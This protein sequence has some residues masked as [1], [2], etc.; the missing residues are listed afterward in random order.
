[1]LGLS[2]TALVAQG[3]S[4]APLSLMPDPSS[5]PVPPALDGTATEN[6]GAKRSRRRAAQNKSAPP[7]KDLPGAPKLMGTT[8]IE[9]LSYAPLAVPQASA[10]V[11]PDGADA[12][13]SE[14]HTPA[15]ANLARA[16]PADVPLP[17]ARPGD[18][19]GEISAPAQTAADLTQPSLFAGVG[20]SMPIEE[21]YAESEE[22]RDE[23]A[24]AVIADGVRSRITLQPSPGA[25]TQAP[26]EKHPQVASLP[27]GSV[28]T[29]GARP[30]VA[31]PGSPDMPILRPST[32]RETELPVPGMNSVY[33]APEA[34][35][36]CLPDGLK[37]VLQDVADKFGHVAILNTRRGR[38][39]GA[40]QSYHYQ[41]RAADFRV[42]GVPFREVMAFLRE[43]PNVGGRKLYP[44][45][46]FHIDDGP[47]RSW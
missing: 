3:A 21:P 42:R 10:D 44:F 32:L 25:G 31:L 26:A 5:L 33:A 28:P 2:P 6:A 37:Q 46:F 24:A 12:A 23:V 13:Q 36:P 19:A 39:T 47:S 4:Q 16:R 17:P 14:P 41:C 34:K 27:D 20:Q 40:R 7:P 15:E 1:M 22:E 35:L 38:G 11:Q 29:L 8:L 18:L 30:N 45:G 43:H 9:P